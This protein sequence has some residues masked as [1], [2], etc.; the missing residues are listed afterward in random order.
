VSSDVSEIFQLADDLGDVPARAVPALRAGMTQAGKEFERTWQNAARR[1]HDNH[2]RFYPESIDSELL[3]GFGT[4]GVEVGPNAAKK[5]GFLGRILEFGGE[6]SPAY[7]LG[8]TALGA[9]E[10]PTERAIDRAM[11][12]LFP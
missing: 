3:P 6:R 2:A 7:L 9:A 4:V 11:N 1:T 10:G 12:P 8:A 5:Q